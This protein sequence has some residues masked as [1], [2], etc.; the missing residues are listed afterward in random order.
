MLLELLKCLDIFAT[1]GIRVSELI[2][3]MHF[4]TNVGSCVCTCIYYTPFQVILYSAVHL[5]VNVERNK[6]TGITLGITNSKTC[7]QR[8]LSKIPKLVSKTNYRLI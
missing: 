8:P 5:S 7:L 4:E 6:F 3:K 2:G 1:D